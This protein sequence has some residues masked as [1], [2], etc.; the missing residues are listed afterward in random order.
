[1]ACRRRNTRNPLFRKRWFSDD[2]IVQCVTWY[3]NF[4]LSYR[5]LAQMM[6]QLGTSVAPCTILRWVIRY[7]VEFAESCRPYEKP[8]RAFVAL[9]RDLY[10]G[11]RPMDVS[12][13]RG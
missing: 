7:S 12:V 5:D 9:R 2:V 8:V 1:M 13:P 4:K 10:S 3:L 6:G 11:W